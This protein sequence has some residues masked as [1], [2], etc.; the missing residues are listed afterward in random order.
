MIGDALSFFRQNGFVLEL[1]TCMVLFT[2]MQEKRSHYI[3][4][5]LACTAAMLSSAMLLNQIALTGVMYN[6]V[7]YLIWFF[8][9]VF[10]GMFTCHMPFPMALFSGISAYI[11]QHMSFK[12]GEWVM[13]FLF[14]HQSW[15]TSNIAYLVVD[16]LMYTLCYFV[17]ARRIKVSDNHFPFH[18]RFG[19]LC[20]GVA[21]FTTIAQY[22][23]TQ[24]AFD[25]PPMICMAYCLLDVICCLFGL[26]LQFGLFRENRLAEEKR[27]MEHIL[28][29]QEE[30]F[31]QSKEN[32]ELINIKCHDLKRQLS[33]IRGLEKEE[34]HQLYRTLNIYDMS[35]KTGNDVL[36]TILAEKSLICEQ[37]HIHLE[38]MASGE[39]LHF[40]STADVY[41]IFGNAIDNAIESVRK[42][43]NVNQRYISLSI[44]ESHGMVV[45]HV[46]NP[47]EGT[48]RFADGLPMTTKPN[49]SFHGFGMKS[50]QMSVEKY[51]GHLAIVPQDHLFSLNIT[52][53]L[54]NQKKA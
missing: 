32:I 41:A 33:S 11:T 26:D 48:L 15:Q 29:M 17:F 24:Y 36:D 49:K 8:M 40:I 12:I 52:I 42:V 27:L 2:S 51:G 37:E 25:L 20:V 46:E 34:L 4:R 50:I 31:R 1:M 13:H 28:H 43:Q 47:Y 22:I 5:L 18:N 38:C 21:I 9:A 7:K 54:A 44:R 30:K 10:S 14:S 23:F 16:I 53:P 39:C 6:F 19:I 35:V 45:F 3:L